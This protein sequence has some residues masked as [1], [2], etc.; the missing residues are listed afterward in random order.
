MN[1]PKDQEIRSFIIKKYKEILL[2]EADR[3]G[4]EHHLSLIKNGQVKLDELDNILKSSQEYKEL[5]SGLNIKILPEP[6]YIFITCFNHYTDE[7]SLLVF[8]EE[9]LNVIFNETGC[10]GCFYQKNYDILF[11]ITRKDPQI[12]C[13]K[14]ENNR[15][16]RIPTYFENYIFGY[17]AHG[18]YISDNRIYVVASD[19]EHDSEKST[20]IDGPSN[21]VGKIIVSEINIKNDG[22]TI[23]NSKMINPFSCSHHHHINDII[24]M[25]DSLYFTS[26]S[27][28]KSIEN[29][30]S[31]GAV[32]NLISDSEC[33]IILDCFE[34]PHSLVYFRDRFY[35]CSS[36]LAIVYSF[37]LQDTIPR[38]EYKGPDGYIRGLLITD[39]YLYIGISES[40]GRTNARFTKQTC[41]LLRFNKIT[42][43]T[44]VIS[45][46][47]EYNNVYSII[48][49]M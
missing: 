32:S 33:E 43:E 48:S 18:V 16:I 35:V 42:G 22:I 17:D 11:C 30:I 38:I 46:P 13:Y 45:L 27:Y 8:N 24:G 49:D 15:F 23:K 3:I 26:F 39:N 1:S 19:G 5:V 36:N 7:G 4:L 37:N 25:D 28:C 12:I 6:D 29:Y 31:R 34:Q 20:N 10:Y 44:K 40:I 47:S 14:K 2:R 9:K 41:R 21:K